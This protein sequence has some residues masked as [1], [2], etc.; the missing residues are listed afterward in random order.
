MSHCCSSSYFIP[1]LKFFFPFLPSARAAPGSSRHND[2]KAARN[3]RPEVPMDLFMFMLMT[4][5]ILICISWER[6][7]HCLRS[8]CRRLFRSDQ[9]KT[10][11]PPGDERQLLKL[12]NERHAID[13]VQ[14]R[15]SSE[16]QSQ[17]GLAQ[18]PQPFSGR[19][20]AHFRAGF[21]V[22]DRLADAV[23]HV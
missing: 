12:F 21:A 6:R 19:E 16:D 11:A 18:C 22:D 3:L 13:F 20:P 4:L 2:K 17:R 15:L 5:S 14:R 9:A 10:P 23:G 8:S 1:S 7:R